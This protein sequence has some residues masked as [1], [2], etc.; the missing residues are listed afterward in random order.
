VWGYVHSG[1]YGVRA[2]D[3]L[4]CITHL[5]TGLRVG[6]WLSSR[7]DAML[8]AE[9]IMREVPQL[10]GMDKPPVKLQLRVMAAIESALGASDA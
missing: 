10:A 1:G 3:G 8:G 7:F 9:A 4:W 6:K 5:R 2:V